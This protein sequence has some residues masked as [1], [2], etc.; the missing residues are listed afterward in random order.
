MSEQP[1]DDEFAVAIDALRTDASTW[2]EFADTMAG[3]ATAAERLT[4]DPLAFSW[5]G[6]QIGISAAYEDVRALMAKLLTEG[7]QNFRDV[8][9]ALITSADAYEQEEAESMR[10]MTGLAEESLS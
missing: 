5:V 7:V 3:A 6:E 1:T 4:V 8:A 9:A 10:R 2:Q